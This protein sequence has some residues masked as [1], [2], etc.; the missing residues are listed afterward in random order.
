MRGR[1]LMLLA[2]VCWCCAV[3]NAYSGG[4]KPSD[5]LQIVNVQFREAQERIVVTYDL[6]TAGSGTSEAPSKGTIVRRNSGFR[7]VLL[8]KRESDL[9][10]TYIPK[11]VG[12]DILAEFL[13][14]FEQ[15]ARDSA[16]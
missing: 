6:V 3:G 16:V 12:G 7:I 2:A 5:S 15:R 8:L 10:F 14:Q 9:S 4:V 1:T 11:Y 13:R